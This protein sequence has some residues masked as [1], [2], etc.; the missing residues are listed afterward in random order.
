M[1]Q[2]LFV[3][4]QK[5]YG[6]K[7]FCLTHFLLLLLK[8]DLFLIFFSKAIMLIVQKFPL[9]FFKLKCNPN[10]FLFFYHLFFFSFR[11]LIVYLLIFFHIEF[12]LFF[13]F[14]SILLS[15]RSF[16]FVIFIIHYIKMLHLI[17]II[18]NNLFIEFIYGIHF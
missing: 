11:H 15:H 1:L 9:V 7:F 18:F 17:L 2:C 8:N 13:H 5:F 10:L 3:F 12:F 6:I 14:F 4:L 16:S